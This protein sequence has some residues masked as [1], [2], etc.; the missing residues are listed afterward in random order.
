MSDLLSFRPVGQYGVSTDMLDSVNT[1]YRAALLQIDAEINSIE[2]DHARRAE[3]RDRLKDAR[4]A[5]VNAYTDWAMVARTALDVASGALSVAA[6][7]TDKQFKYYAKAAGAASPVAGQ[8]N[9]QDIEEQRGLS[10]MAESLQREIDGD[11][12]K[13]EETLQRV[14]RLIEQIGDMRMQASRS[15]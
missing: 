14:N 9:Q 1:E 15:S 5:L 8:L 12:R 13:A 11:T 10:Q 7:T 4:K 2:N 3:L 6:G